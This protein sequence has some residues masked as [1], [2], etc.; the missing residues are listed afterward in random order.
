MNFY[1]WLVVFL[2]MSLLALALNLR[3][4]RRDRRRATQLRM[5]LR[6][7]PVLE[8]TAGNA[9]R[10]SFLVAAWNENAVIRRCIEAVL[11][12]AYPNYELILC[13]GGEDVSYA[14]AAQYRGDRAVILE[15]KAG[16]GKQHSLQRCLENAT[17][18][19]IYL[20]DADC[21]ITD[22]VFAWTLA[23][24]I[25]AGE[26]AVSGSLYT[27]FP[28]QLGNPFVFNQCITRAY[29]AAHQ[30]AYI[31]GLLGGNCAV[32]RDTLEQAGAF[33]TAIKTGTDYDLAKRLVQ[34]G[35][36][37]K[38]EVNASIQSQFPTRVK[39]Y[40]RQQARW[41][42]NV[43]LHGLR[44]HA[45]GEVLSCLRTS[46]VGCGMLLIPCLALP[47]A[48]G[49][50]M[51]FQTGMALIA[52]WIFAIFYALFSRLRYLGFARAWLGFQPPLRILPYLF[53]FLWIDFLAWT[54]PLGEYA[55]K[56]LRERW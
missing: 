22:T 33:K 14:I 32:R 25:N 40:F 46:L 47:L 48:F 39:E 20:I 31:T 29:S 24:I 23:P 38:Y 37:I 56:P 27:P 35:V 28:E 45:Y 26:Q 1:A 34:N 8:T 13:A 55:F 15:Q 2:V 11:D 7:I 53:A 5:M 54:I 52:G 16:E 51:L 41:V 10:V 44:F 12:L 18:E 42:R 21:L 19:I 17:G 6:R 9:P 4:L 3:L 30:P 36:R 50:S 43:T 49:P